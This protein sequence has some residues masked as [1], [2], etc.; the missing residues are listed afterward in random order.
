MARGHN[1]ICGLN[2]VGLR[3]AGLS[4]A[5]RLELKELYHALFRN[6][7]NLKA[8]LAQ[9]QGVEMPITAEVHQVLFEGKEPRSAVTDLMVRRPKVESD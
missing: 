9:A 3:R 7:L 5:E 1:G 8:A 4:H 6:G 2:T